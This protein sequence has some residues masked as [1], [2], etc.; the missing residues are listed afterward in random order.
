MPFR[1]T[2]VVYC[3]NHTEHTDIVRTSQETLYISSSEIHMLMLFRKTVALYCENHTEHLCG[4]FECDRT[5]GTY[6]NHGVLKRYIIQSQGVETHIASI[7]SF[8]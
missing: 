7:F 5:G 4:Q 1:K 8:L 6:G 2:V 3:E